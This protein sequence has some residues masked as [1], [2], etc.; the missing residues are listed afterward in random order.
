MGGC[1]KGMRQIR[2]AK[3]NDIPE[4][5][6][7]LEQNLLAFKKNLDTNTLEQQGFLIHGFTPEEAKTSILDKDYSI[8]L[9]STENNE[10]IGYAMGCDITKL[11]E[12]P[13]PVSS[14]KTFYLKHIAKKPD[15]NNVGKELLRTLFELAKEKGYKN[16]ICQIAHKPLQNKASITFHEKLGFM[17]ISE[18]QEED[19]TFGVYLKKIYAD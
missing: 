18:G 8:F 9:I 19:K 3:L 11:K 16:I 12:P 7:V 13:T 5:I 15:K 6:S 2:F 1:R 17:C 14:E 10:V 4:I